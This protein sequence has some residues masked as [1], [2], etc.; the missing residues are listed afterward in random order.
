MTGNARAQTPSSS[1]YGDG[2][3]G[4]RGEGGG[5]RSTLG[6]FT[7]ESACFTRTFNT[8]PPANIA[9]RRYKVPS[10]ILKKKYKF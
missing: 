6:G 4:A 5:S 9:D 1:Y 3:G 7:T 2:G 10:F 8:L